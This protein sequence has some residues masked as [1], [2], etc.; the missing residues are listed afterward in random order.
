M[1]ISI[2]DVLAEE[3]IVWVKYLDDFSVQL[4]YL[5]PSKLTAMYEKSRYRD[6][7][8][9]T[10]TPIEKENRDV[11][12]RQLSNNIILDWKGLTVATLGK[13][14]PLVSGVDPKTEVA[15]STEEAYLLLSNS[16]DFSAFVQN[17]IFDV[18]RFSAEEEDTEKKT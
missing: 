1:A 12:I 8:K 13:I 9:K 15:F 3:K 2:K 4:K 10:H 5:T 17:T 11:L 16:I 6:W 14:I 18:Q 7:D